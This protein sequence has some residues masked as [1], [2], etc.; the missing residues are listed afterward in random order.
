MES[1]AKGQ[2]DLTIRIGNNRRDEIGEMTRHF[3][4]SCE[5]LRSM[6]S[7]VSRR[8]Q[9]LG[10]LGDDLVSAMDRTSSAVQAILVQV[11]TVKRE[12]I[13][14]AAGVTESSS[15]VEQIAGNIESLDGLIGTQVGG[16]AESSAAVEQMLANA[17]ST[18]QTIDHMVQQFQILLQAA[19][20]GLS[21]QETVRT[22]IAAI[23]EQSRTLLE[24]NDAIAPDCFSNQ[25]AGHE[26]CH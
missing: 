21:R 20:E 18:S 11:E 10:T 16:V 2:G 1:V 5:A 8:S 15:A 13:N 19:E 7:E 23:E 9:G 22:T 6:V 4:N 25:L 12:T 26:C 24:A 14:Q 17:A 3:D